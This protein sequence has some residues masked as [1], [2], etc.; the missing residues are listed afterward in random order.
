MILYPDAPV[1]LIVMIEQNYSSDNFQKRYIKRQYW[2]KE[3]DGQWK[4]I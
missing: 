2:R 1:L 4:I 3:K